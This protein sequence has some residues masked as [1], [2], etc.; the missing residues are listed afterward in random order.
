MKGL[1][2]HHEAEGCLPL[3]GNPRLGGARCYHLP[4]PV[5]QAPVNPSSIFLFCWRRPESILPAYVQEPWLTHK[6]PLDTCSFSKTHVPK[7]FLSSCCSRRRWPAPERQ[8]PLLPPRALH[9]PP[10]WSGSARPRPPPRRARPAAKQR[11]LCTFPPLPW[12][13]G[14]RPQ[15]SVGSAVSCLTAALRSRRG[16]RFL[17][18]HNPISPALLTSPLGLTFPAEPPACSKSLLTWESPR[19]CPHPASQLPP[20]SREHLNWRRSE[21][22]SGKNAGVGSVEQL[23]D[24]S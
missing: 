11:W 19:A 5:L 12:C 22:R 8:L 17:Q 4:Q 3:K 23:V 14:P 10:R 2:I 21:S 20:S 9:P 13:L 16:R 6:A 18:R 1:R 24:P 7:H 15:V